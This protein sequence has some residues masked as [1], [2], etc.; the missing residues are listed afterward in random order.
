[1]LLIYRSHLT[2]E[3]NLKVEKEVQPNI[4]KTSTTFL[5]FPSKKRMGYA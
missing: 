5:S 4:S 1:M 2:I 3:N